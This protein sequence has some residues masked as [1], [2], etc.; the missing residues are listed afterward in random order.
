MRMLLILVLL[1]ALAAGGF[2]SR[3]NEEAQR[4]NADTEI[5]K[6][7]GSDGIGGLIDTVVGGITREA[8][9]EDLL[10]ATKYTVTSGGKTAL[11]CLGA[12]SQFFCSKP[13]AK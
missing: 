1:G 11:E 5:A 2:L 8:K 7:S 10:V 12:F 3:P 4:R 13:D 6:A 9:Y